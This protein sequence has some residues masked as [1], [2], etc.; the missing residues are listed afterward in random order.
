MLPLHHSREITLRLDKQHCIRLF[1]TLQ[2]I[3]FNCIV[4]HPVSARSGSTIDGDASS[5]A[6][7]QR[8]DRSQ[9]SAI[10]SKNL[11]PERALLS[12]ERC[13]LFGPPRS[14]NSPRS[15]SGYRCLYE[16]QGT[17]RRFLQVN[18]PRLAVCV[19]ETV[20]GRRRNSA[21]GSSPRSRSS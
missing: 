9:V 6:T 14:A 5:V 17:S 12:A 18:Y 10:L 3:L 11:R 1:P 16:R 19:S 20:I 13:A 4:L 2:L 8:P 7:V 21:Y 15:L